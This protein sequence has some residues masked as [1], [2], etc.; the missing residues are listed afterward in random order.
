MQQPIAYEKTVAD[1]GEGKGRGRGG[2]GPLDSKDPTFC[3]LNNGCSLRACSR[4]IDENNPPCESSL[5]EQF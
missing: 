4:E 2:G 1:P 3:S 5:E